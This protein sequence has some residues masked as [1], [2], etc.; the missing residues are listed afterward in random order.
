MVTRLRCGRP[1]TGRGGGQGDTLDL[2]GIW[3]G[4]GSTRTERARNNVSPVKRTTR[5]SS[6]VNRERSRQSQPLCVTMTSSWKPHARTRPTNAPHRSL[7]S[8]RYL[9]VGRG[10]N[11]ESW[12]SP[13]EAQPPSFHL[14][15][16]L[17]GGTRGSCRSAPEFWAAANTRIRDRWPVHHET[18]ELSKLHSRT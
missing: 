10:Q 3:T 8:L 4:R 9:P 15:R 16:K 14:G 18:P 7:V 6:S 1:G 12:S 13:R 5:E 2:R 17:G 11:D